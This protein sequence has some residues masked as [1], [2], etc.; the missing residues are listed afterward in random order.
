MPT[1]YI[2]VSFPRVLTPSSLKRT[3]YIYRHIA[4]LRCDIHT[5]FHIY[6]KYHT[7]D[8]ALSQPARIRSIVSMDNY[9]VVKDLGA[10]NFAVARIMRHKET[11]QLVA[12]KYIMRGQ[13][14]YMC[15]DFYTCVISYGFLMC[16][17]ENDDADQ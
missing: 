2:Q 16:C 4:S 14:I 11:K 5:H 12:M 3:T 9:E 13:K 15:I 17:V 10:G 6:T 8:R 7:I 1:P